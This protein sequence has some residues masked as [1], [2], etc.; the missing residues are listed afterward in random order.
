MATFQNKKV[1]FSKLKYAGELRIKFTSDPMP[2]K[3]NKND[4][5][6]FFEVEGD[7]EKYNLVIE[8]ESIADQ[9]RATPKNRWV[10][11]LAEGS[12]AE[13]QV[14]NITDAGGQTDAPAGRYG[15][16][17]I[18][19]CFREVADSVSGITTVWDMHGDFAPSDDA[20][21]LIG[22]VMD[23]WFATGR[24]APLYAGQTIGGGAAN[25]DK[26]ESEDGV[27]ESLA[28]WVGEIKW[29]GKSHDNKDLPKI[30]K[31]IL[32]I[33]NNQDKEKARAALSWCA[34]EYTYQDNSV[35]VNEEV[36]F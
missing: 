17:D 22:L 28:T 6:A 25:E 33:L 14:L 23:K 8:T 16:D 7:D 13:D 10:T 24:F 3:F 36:P 26:T 9:V 4:L 1:W 30:K 5:I 31:A 34:E 20:K 18:M 12:S 21:W 19:S 15:P 35:D 11:V 32:E 2:S 27:L 29:S